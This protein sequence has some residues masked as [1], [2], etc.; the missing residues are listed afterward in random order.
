MNCR[1]LEK[2]FYSV[3]GWLASTKYVCWHCA[4]KIAKRPLQIGN[5]KISCKSSNNALHHQG[6]G[7]SKINR[8]SKQID[9]PPIVNVLTALVFNFKETCFFFANYSIEIYL[10]IMVHTKNEEKFEFQT[11]KSHETLSL[12]LLK[13]T[14]RA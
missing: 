3:H 4:D 10:M 6:K 9:N 8:W 1:R 2:Y 7:G 13:M 5:C 14:Y 12:A 11:T